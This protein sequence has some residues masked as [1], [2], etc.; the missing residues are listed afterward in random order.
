MSSST[1][2]EC[3]SGHPEG[4][5]RDEVRGRCLSARIARLSLAHVEENMNMSLSMKMS[6]KMSLSLSLSLSMS[7]SLSLGEGDLRFRAA[8]P[9]N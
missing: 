6:M 8:S 9:R 5:Q 1:T 3:V 7:L 2:S 4:H